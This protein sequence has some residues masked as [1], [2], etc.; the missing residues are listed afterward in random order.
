[1]NKSLIIA[2]AA[3]SLAAGAALAGD[4]SDDAGNGMKTEGSMNPTA[5]PGAAS[6]QQP[7]AETSDRTP[8]KSTTTPET[9]VDRS[10]GGETSDRTPEH[11]TK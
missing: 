5:A 2:F 4:K 8:D 3:L 9:Q 7:G 11:H 10:T 1:M 6:N